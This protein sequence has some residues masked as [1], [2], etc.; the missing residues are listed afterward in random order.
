MYHLRSS[1]TATATEDDIRP[2]EGA[3]TS[4]HQVDEEVSL[5][6]VMD[7]VR[8]DDSVSQAGQS[9]SAINTRAEA[10]R[11][12]AEFAMLKKDSHLKQNRY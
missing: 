3:A 11:L 4:R 2:R 12:K 6:A 9:V 8:S 7:T 10:A 5:S 1:S